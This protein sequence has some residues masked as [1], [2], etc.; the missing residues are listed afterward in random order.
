MEAIIELTEPFERYVIKMTRHDDREKAHQQ[1][2]A[3]LFYLL[4]SKGYNRNLVFCHEKKLTMD[5][6]FVLQ[7]EISFGPSNIPDDIFNNGK[8]EIRLPEFVNLLFN[9][10]V[11]AD[12]EVIS[13]ENGRNSKIWARKNKK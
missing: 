11:S 3:R 13:L 1:I 7:I 4:E 8:K 2:V 12:I 6:E 10:W 9:E 5:G